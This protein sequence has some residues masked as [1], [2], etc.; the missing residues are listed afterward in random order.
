MKKLD[1]HTIGINCILEKPLPAAILKV[2][3]LLFGLSTRAYRISPIIFFDFCFLQF[4]I[5]SFK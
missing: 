4:F 5:F 2:P 3:Q 1:R